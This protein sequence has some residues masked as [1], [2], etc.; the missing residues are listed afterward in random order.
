MAA[1]E[2]ENENEVRTSRLM[3]WGFPTG[4]VIFLVKSQAYCSTEMGDKVF[5][6]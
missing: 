4:I 6:D 2:T 3:R 5:L 1:N